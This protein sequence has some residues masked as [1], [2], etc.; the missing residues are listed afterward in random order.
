MG[1]GG[2][3][4]E[5]TSGGGGE[6]ETEKRDTASPKQ[7]HRINSRGY[8]GRRETSMR[9]YS[10]GVKKDLKLKEK[11]GDTCERSRLRPPPAQRQRESTE[12]NFPEN[13]RTCKL[14]GKAR[15]CA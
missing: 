12:T 5:R 3:G 2:R 4:F 7:I 6:R 14:F 9:M 15:V 11:L 1:G 8:R 10:V 13:K